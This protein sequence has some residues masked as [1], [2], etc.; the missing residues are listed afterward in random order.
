MESETEGSFLVINLNSAH[1]TTLDE[2]GAEITQTKGKYVPQI[3]SR[4]KFG[5]CAL[6]SYSKPRVSEIDFTATNTVEIKYRGT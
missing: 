4:C 3:P 2:S 6:V 5:L 1:D